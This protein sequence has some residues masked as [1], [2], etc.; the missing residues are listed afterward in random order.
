M[1]FSEL[2]RKDKIKLIYAY[3]ITPILIIWM[4]G[5]NIYSEVD[6]KYGF[7]TVTSVSCGTVIGLGMIN[8][9]L[10]L[11]PPTLIR[12][13]YFRRDLQ[14]GIE[15]Y[16]SMLISL[17]ATT[18]L[19]YPFAS[20][21]SSFVVS[22]GLLGSLSVYSVLSFGSR[23]MNTF[24]RMQR[25][26]LTLV[27][28]ATPFLILYMQNNSTTKPQQVYFPLWEAIVLSVVL[29]SY[30][31]NPSTAGNTDGSSHQ[32]SQS[33][34]QG[35]SYRFEESS[36]QSRTPDETPEQRLMNIGLASIGRKTKIMNKYMTA[37]RIEMRRRTEYPFLKLIADKYK[38]ENERKILSKHFM[39]FKE[40][41][42][43][44]AI[45]VILRAKK[46]EHERVKAD[47]THRLSDGLTVQVRSW[48]DE[49]WRTLTKN[50]YDSY[51]ASDDIE[52]SLSKSFWGTLSYKYSYILV[53]EDT[54]IQSAVRLNEIFRYIYGVISKEYD[55][56]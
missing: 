31:Y 36:S 40:M 48:R 25:Y 55:T 27:T 3:V 26:I 50:F 45:G 13:L 10:L 49:Y 20:L 23:R 28:L 33:T 42:L 56:K 51:T 35:T 53:T 2:S 11:F 30:V 38:D 9:I 18:F 6:A 14:Y 47:L 1:S 12:F 46:S 43:F 4:T 52:L 32:T 44:I 41:C 37:E 5:G 8:S 16:C 34:S 17:A 54:V 29:N 22:A 7:E 24:P 21:F 15:I 19:L 39:L